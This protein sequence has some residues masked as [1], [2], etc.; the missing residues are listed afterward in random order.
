MANI[1]PSSTTPVSKQSSM[2]PSFDYDDIIQSIKVHLRNTEEFKDVDWNGSA[3]KTLI[4][5]LA[6]NTQ[7]QQT[8]N[9]FVF[10]ELSFDTATIRNNLASLASSTGYV[11][12]G[13]RASKVIVNIKV[14]VTNL[15]DILKDSIVLKRDT[16]FTGGKDGSA[17]VFMPNDHYIGNLTFDPTTGSKYYLFENVQLLQGTWVSYA[18]TVQTQYTIER[19][20]IPNK[21]VD[22]STIT[23]AVLPNQQINKHDPYKRAMSIYDLGPDEKVYFLIVDRDGFY[24]IEF[25][26]GLYGRRLKYGEVAYI[27]YLVTDGEQGNDLTKINPEQGIDGKYNITVEMVSP[28]SYGG[29]D[30]EGIETI[31]KLAPMA[32]VAQSHCV[33]NND[34]KVMVKMLWPDAASVIS[35]GGDQNMPPKYGYQIIGVKPKSSAAMNAAQKAELVALLTPRCVASITPL[36]ID[37]DYTYIDLNV[38]CFYVPKK[39]I[40]SEQS[41]TKKIIQAIREYSKVTLEDFGTIYNHFDM[42]KFI[43][44]IDGSIYSV[45]LVSTISKQFTPEL[46]I[47]GTYQFD[48]FTSIAPESVYIKNYILLDSQSIGWTYYMKDDGLGN[49]VSEKID[50]SGNIQ[51]FSATAGTVDYENG[52][53]NISGFSPIAVLNSG[54]Y[55]S[56]DTVD[57]QPEI[58][59]EL[60][61]ILEINNINVSMTPRYA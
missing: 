34:F 57:V 17:Y 44:T 36:I 61:G 18:Y 51:R 39:T 1:S 55:I 60:S 58:V 37:P 41:L 38:S 47:I 6:Y 56:V 26:D 21:N 14:D 53:I 12:Y 8:Q 13:K 45:K 4:G 27:D 9:S 48:F 10:N 40:L 43:S 42:V 22:I 23:V 16:A 15:T 2:T 46:N 7:I 3:A 24:N 29:D 54:V 11:P 31:R 25:C 20:K 32:S 33:T 28:K 59:S 19:Y 52:I 35:W 50:E 5:I 49:L 30:V